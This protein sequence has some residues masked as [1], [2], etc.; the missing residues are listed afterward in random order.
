MQTRIKVTKSVYDQ[1]KRMLAKYSIN[2]IHVR[3]SVSPGTIN[4]IQA[5][6][7]EVI[8]GRV[9]QKDMDYMNLI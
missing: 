7:V 4:A 8:P 1:V 5:G 9:K 3:T 6:N 2:A